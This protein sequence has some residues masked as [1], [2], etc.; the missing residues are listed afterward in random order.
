MKKRILFSQKNGTSILEGINQNNSLL[1]ITF[2]F[3]V[4]LLAGVLY[5][6]AKNTSGIFYA[7]DFKNFY[8][9]ISG[10]FATTFFFAF[11]RQLPFAA[12]IFLAGTC[13]VGAV[14]V[15]AIVALRG[16]LYGVIMSYAYATYGLMGIVFNLLILIPSAILATIALML[17]ARE[18]FGFSLSLARLALPTMQRPAIEQDFKRYCLRQLFVF[19]FFVVSAIVQTI[20]ALSFLSFFELMQ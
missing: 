10:G 2:C 15:P 12:A 8:G 5:F 1:L 19:L 16:A 18:A 20:M 14:L 9:E 11:L 13:M 17:S 6:E 3:L 4:G 7:D